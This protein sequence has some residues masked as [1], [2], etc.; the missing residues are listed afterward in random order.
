M[1]HAPCHYIV[2]QVMQVMQVFDFMDFTDF[3]D[4]GL[5]YELPA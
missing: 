5:H 3:M 1:L 2:M 4:F